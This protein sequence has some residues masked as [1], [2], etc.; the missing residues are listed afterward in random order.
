[1]FEALRK[2]IFPIII[3]VLLFFVGMIVLQW[4]LGMSSRGVSTARNV[5]G[6]INGEEI[7]W[8]MYS[9]TYNNLYQAE[10]V[11][12]DEEQQLSDEKIQELKATAWNQILADRLIMQQI[13]KQNIVV[14]DQEVYDYLKGYPPQ[15]LQAMPYFQTEGRFDYQKYLTAMADPNMAAFWTE[16][17]PIVRVDI[18]KMKLQEMI[19]QTAHVT[20]PEVKNY[21]METNERVKVGLVNVEFGRF[22]APPPSISDEESEQY[23]QDNLDEFKIGEQASLGIC[24]LEKA[25]GREDW[26]RTFEQATAIYDSI[27][28]GADFKALAKDLS[29]DVGSALDSGSLGWFPPGRMVSEF[30]R[31]AFSMQV[32]EVSEP[33]RTQF[34]WHILKHHG[35]RDSET[36]STSSTPMQE[37]HVSHILIKTF[38]SASALDVIHERLQTFRDEA[39][40]RGFFVVAEELQLPATTTGLFQ[41]DSNIPQLGSNKTAEIFAFEAKLGTISE[42]LENESAFYVL[43][44]AK[45]E[46]EG[47]AEFVKVKDE[48]RMTLQ[49]SKVQTLCL[50]T[51]NAIWAEIQSGTDIK[52]AA[53][54]HGETYDTTS[55]FARGAY[56]RGLGRS[57][58]AIGAAFGLKAPGDMTPP[59]EHD[60]G[61]AIL[62]LLEKN[63]PDLTEFTA[64]RDSLRMTILNSKRQELFGRWYQSLVETSEIIDNTQRVGDESDYM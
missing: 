21:F 53:E 54:D 58:E 7:S 31:I 18:R 62:E 24:M 22:S 35:Y 41:R 59:I 64:K 45:R 11:K 42:V 9:R 2:M 25:P 20:E 14:T 19:V 8:P 48:I 32:D 55:E 37:A 10:A 39:E 3:I 46:M 44:A 43:E 60:Q 16:M 26:A 50:D 17:D 36:P 29:E 34:G 49:K 15:N 61:C 40:E 5:A 13:A 12:L 4:G 1:M 57:P 51:A 63:S 27:M 56:V 30:D 6:I 47:H 23:Y 33:V 38:A 52:Q 28:G